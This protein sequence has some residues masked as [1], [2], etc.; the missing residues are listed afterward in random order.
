MFLIPYYSSVY[1]E[2][3]KLSFQRDTRLATIPCLDLTS[4]AVAILTSRTDNDS[5][6]VVELSETE[7][8]LRILSFFFDSY[9]RRDLSEGTLPAA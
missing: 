6:A 5:M 7:C 4:A 8:L 1:V 2:A 3:K 9:W